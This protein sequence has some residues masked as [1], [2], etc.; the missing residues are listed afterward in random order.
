M[1]KYLIV[2]WTLIC[3]CSGWYFHVPKTITKLEVKEVDKP[4]YRV[5]KQLKFDDNTG[6]WSA[7]TSPIIITHTES[8]SIMTVKASDGYKETSQDLQ[9]GQTTNWKVCA[10][11][12]GS[13]FV[14]GAACMVKAL[15]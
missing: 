12:G 15:R 2:I 6:L 10:I 4:V 7:Y 3:F 9:I 13:A 11:V 8:R 5:V 14:L 1:K